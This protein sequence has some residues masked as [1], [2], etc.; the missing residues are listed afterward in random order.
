[1]WKHLELRGSMY[2]HHVD[3]AM[4]NDCVI[5]LCV[6]MVMCPRSLYQTP[7]SLTGDSHGFA[8]Q[9]EANASVKRRTTLRL[10]VDGTAALHEFQSLLHVVETKP[11]VR[12]CRCAVKAHAAIADRKVNLIRCRPQLSI[13]P[14]HAAMQ[15][16]I[17]QG[18]L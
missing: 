3:K 5:S 16:R 15:H 13:E 9:T 17:V 10:R 2:G 14:P 1:M 18:F 4:W 12:L 6:G 7:A 11:S 8:Y